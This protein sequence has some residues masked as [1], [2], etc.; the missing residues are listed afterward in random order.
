MA[1]HVSALEYTII[2]MSIQVS[3][4][5]CISVE[6]ELNSCAGGPAVPPDQ[7]SHGHASLGSYV[8]LGLLSLGPNVLVRMTGPLMFILLYIVCM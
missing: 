2:I 8:P 4:T 6:S 1:L 3:C 7:V 5:L